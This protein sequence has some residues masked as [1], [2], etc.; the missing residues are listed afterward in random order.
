MFFKSTLKR[1]NSE[2]VEIA[3]DSKEYGYLTL[4]LEYTD[5]QDSLKKEKNTQWEYETKQYMEYDESKTHE[6]QIHCNIIPPIIIKFVPDGK[7]SVN[8]IME[9]KK[10]HTDMRMFLSKKNN[11]GALKIVYKDNKLNLIMS[12]FNNECCIPIEREN[13]PSILKILDQL[14]IV[15]STNTF[16]ELDLKEVS[17][18]STQ[19][20]HNIKNYGMK[21]FR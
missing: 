8:Q 6:K 18:A 2:N 20:Y 11:D 1:F 4:K 21:F 3:Y 14:C 16:F 15:V 9:F 17:V 5:L 10:M 13:I 7:L 19:Y 12:H